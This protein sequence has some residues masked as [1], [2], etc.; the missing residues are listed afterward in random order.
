MCFVHL[1]PRAT[2]QED[3]LDIH[4]ATAARV[5]YPA[6]LGRCKIDAARDGGF[7]YVKVR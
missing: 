3:M 2:S 1:F 7:D 6:P 5:K 4:L